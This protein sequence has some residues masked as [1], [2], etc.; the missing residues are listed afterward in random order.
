MDPFGHIA[1]SVFKK[2]YDE[3]V[4]V[5][6]TIAITKAHL[7]VLEI[8]EAVRFGRIPIDGKIVLASTSDS[9]ANKLATATAGGASQD[10]GVEVNV[11]KAAVEPVWYLP[12]VAERFGISEGL[13]RRALF[14]DSGGSYPELITRPE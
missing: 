14:E 1:P 8:D 4:D 13:L 5:R 10:L 2:Q 11:S 9:V 7:K 3:G 12:G 6:P